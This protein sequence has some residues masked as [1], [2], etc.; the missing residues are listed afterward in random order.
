M[1]ANCP[2]IPAVGQV[3]RCRGR[4]WLVDAA[5]VQATAIHSEH[6]TDE[7]R[8]ALD[9][10]RDGVVSAICAP[11]I[12]DEGIDVPDADLGVILA[13]SRQRRQMI[14]R[15]GRVL[16]R[17]ADGREARF[18]VVYVR[19]TAEEPESG[20]HKAFLEEITSVALAHK[21]FGPSATTTSLERF[22]G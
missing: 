20:A 1:A 18:A 9:E 16:R 22:L 3:V 4:A 12:L 13:A 6:G 11:R 7:R 19:G 21:S 14:Q 10:F 8:D 15:M 2:P 5:D 17:K